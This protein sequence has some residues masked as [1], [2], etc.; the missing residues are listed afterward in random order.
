MTAMSIADL[1]ADVLEEW[2]AR[3]R[4]WQEERARRRRPARPP[5]P[6]GVALGERI[7]HARHEAGLSQFALAAA[8]EL[9]PSTISRWEHGQRLPGLE[10]L[11]A[12]AR[13]LGARATELMPD[14]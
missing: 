11:Y 7:A 6:L 5:S 9:D 12:L 13:V 4:A 8:L 3:A 14:E 2:T 1:D 10:H